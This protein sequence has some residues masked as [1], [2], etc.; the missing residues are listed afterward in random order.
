MVGEESGAG[1]PGQC[2]AGARGA[3]AFLRRGPAPRAQPRRRALPGPS[4]HPGPPALSAGAGGPP[5]A[6]LPPRPGAVGRPLLPGARSPPAGLPPLGPRVGVVVSAL[7]GRFYPESE[8][9]SSSS[10]APP[11]PTEFPSGL[12]DLGRVASLEASALAICECGGRG[13]SDVWD[14]DSEPKSPLSESLPSPYA[15]G[16]RI[17]FSAPLITADSR[18]SN[19]NNLKSRPWRGRG[20]GGGRAGAPTEKLIGKFASSWLPAGSQRESQR[21][22]P[23]EEPWEARLISHPSN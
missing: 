5:G 3:P 12:G 18:W 22:R 16:C 7:R 23:S 20:S 19:K 10:V 15:L 2:A 17:C 8:R 4:R 21:S 6:T 14:W 1:G 13:L 11:S 9:R